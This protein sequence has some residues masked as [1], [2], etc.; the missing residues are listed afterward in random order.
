MPAT[1][2]VIGQAHHASPASDNLDLFSEDPSN[3]AMPA[4]PDQV[5]TTT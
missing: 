2:P 4:T 5:P 1:P 3:P